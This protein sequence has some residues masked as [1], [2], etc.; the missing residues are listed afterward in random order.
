MVP[1]AL[2]G[3]AALQQQVHDGRDE[4]SLLCNKITTKVTA[5]EQC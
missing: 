5:E 1:A 2:K 4:V 3:L